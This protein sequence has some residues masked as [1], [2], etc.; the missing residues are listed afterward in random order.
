MKCFLGETYDEG[1]SSAKKRQSG[2]QKE[3][4]QPVVMKDDNDNGNNNDD[5]ENGDEENDGAVTGD[6]RITSLSNE[7]IGNIIQF[8]GL[9]DGPLR[10]MATCRHFA[11]SL[12]EKNFAFHNSFVDAKLLVKTILKGNTTME[13]VLRND[14]RVQDLPNCGHCDHTNRVSIV[15]CPTMKRQRG[16]SYVEAYYSCAECMKVFARCALCNDM[17][18]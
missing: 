2:T 14:P 1:R 4:Q 7:I 18:L 9:D 3:E 10:L 12:S 13:D 16:S 15:K 8:L 6:C 11:S 5:D 17:L